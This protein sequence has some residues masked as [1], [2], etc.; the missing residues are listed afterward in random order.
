MPVPFLGYKKVMFVRDFYKALW[1]HTANSSLKGFVVS[2]NGGVGL[3]WW[4]VWFLIK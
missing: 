1:E 3:S 4:L 2:G